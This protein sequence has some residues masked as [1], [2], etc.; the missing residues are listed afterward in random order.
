MG[1]MWWVWP[2]GSSWA[3]WEFMCEICAD[4]RVT[5][6]IFVR[7]PTFVQIKS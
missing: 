1:G 6:D 4:R 5:W 2:V 7:G 3:H